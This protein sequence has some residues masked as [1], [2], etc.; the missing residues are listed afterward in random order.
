MTT[1]APYFRG[2]FTPANAALAPDANGYNLSVAAPTEDAVLHTNHPL[3]QPLS[4]NHFVELLEAAT[5]AAGHDH[6]TMN[7]SKGKRRRSST[8]GSE[9]DAASSPKR[10]RIN[11]ESGLGYNA[12][13]EALYT[14][15]TLGVHSAAA[16]FRRSSEKAPRKHTRPPMSKLFM[17][18]QLSP[19]SFLHLQAKAKAYML[20]PAHPERQSCVGNRGKSD[21]DMVKLKLFNCVRDFLADGVGECFFG[22]NVVDKNHT[23]KDALEAAHALGVEQVRTDNKLVWPKDGIQLIGLVTPLLR[24]MVTNERQRVYAIE[25]RKGGARRKEASVEAVDAAPLPTE[26]QNPVQITM[27]SP[28]QSHVSP[29]AVAS[30]SAHHTHDSG[31]CHPQSQTEYDPA[32]VNAPLPSSSL[33]PRSVIELP[34]GEKLLLPQEPDQDAYIKHIN[35]F[36]KKNSCIIGSVRFHHTE[37][38]PLFHLAWT[39]L[40]GRID[41]LVDE[42]TQ[43][44]YQLTEERDSMARE[45]LRKDIPSMGPETLRGLAV[46]ATKVQTEALLNDSAS[47]AFSP[48]PEGLVQAIGPAVRESTPRD[49]V[50]CLNTRR[51]S[52][53]K[54]VLP[55]RIEAM[56]SS[57]RAVIRD[58]KEWET[59]KLDVAFADLMDQTLN[60][61]AILC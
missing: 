43:K 5:T 27:L 32:L 41:L 60:V 52:D 9:A 20:D 39:E 3:S 2:H 53:H 58:S 33:L 4:N 25:T 15:T 1:N 46:A 30:R 42:A 31:A 50:D 61:V 37:E 54:F 7:V 48:D 13:K 8:L 28:V 45:S 26:Q 11:D 29:L 35:V 17:S 16:L 57:G 36:M 10:V 24:R 56:R 47:T 23:E 49:D 18:L 34:Q 55:Y 40:L 12:G 44:F 51:L 14:S 59:L 38:A 6:Q 19:E 21:T 22:E